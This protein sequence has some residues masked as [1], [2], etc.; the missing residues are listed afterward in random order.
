MA[1]IQRSRHRVCM[2]RALFFVWEKMR[3]FSLQLLRRNSGIWKICL[4]MR[5]D[6]WMLLN[7]FFCSVD[8]SFSPL[9]AITMSLCLIVRAE[10]WTHVAYW[11]MFWMC[12]V[13]LKINLSISV[14]SIVLFPTLSSPNIPHL[15]ANVFIHLL[16]RA[17]P[18][19]PSWTS[20]YSTLHIQPITN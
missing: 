20:L 2:Y 9:H 7:L 6:F 5:N 4:N 15:L 10:L 3:R 16:L 8:R 19:G 17:E 14:L 13:Y 1:V 11:L 12:K 18:F